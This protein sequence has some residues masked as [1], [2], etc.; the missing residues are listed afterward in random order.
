MTRTLT[1]TTALVAATALA[2]PALAQ[3][4]EIETFEAPIVGTEGSQIGTLALRG[5]PNGVVGTIT[6][7][8]G[9]LPGGWHA[10]HFHHVGDCSDAPEFQASQGHITSEGAMHGYLHP[11]GPEAGDL[12]NFYA[13]T[14]GAAIAEVA[15]SLLTFDGDQA[16]FD[17]DGSALV[18]HEGR[19]DHVTQPIGGAG[20]RLACA[21][22]ERQ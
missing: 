7:E 2:A 20:S 13:G 18:V 14:N 16:L 3:E 6:I 8:E 5:G 11:Q 15:T 9:G 19:D 12:A 22:I 21:V 10:A 17:D 4:S 1:L